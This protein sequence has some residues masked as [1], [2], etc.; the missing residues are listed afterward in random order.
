METGRVNLVCTDHCPFPKAD[1]AAG[2]EDIWEAP[3][4]IPGIEFMAAAQA[5]DMRER[6]EENPYRFGYGT[7]KAKEVIR[8]YVEY[9]DI[10]RPLYPD[11]NSM[12]NLVDSC[13][14]L[15]EVEAEV[16]NLE[17]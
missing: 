7:T 13:E 4:G 17:S 8:R 1:K 12:K 9:L 3:Y 16:G 5:L 15:D 11:H 14:I 2:I 10:D 6:M